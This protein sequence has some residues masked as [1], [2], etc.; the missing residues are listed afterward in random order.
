MLDLNF[1]NVILLTEP[2]KL[3]GEGIYNLNALKEIKVTDSFLGLD[4]KKCQTKESYSDCTSKLYHERALKDCGCLPKS[5][6]MSEKVQTK[7]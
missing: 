3:V 1:I 5:T 4:T 6:M 7:N 2:V